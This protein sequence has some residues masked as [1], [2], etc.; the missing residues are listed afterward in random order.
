MSKRL[1]NLLEDRWYL[2]SHIYR[3]GWC[4]DPA[5]QMRLVIWNNVEMIRIN[6]AAFEFLDA[7]RVILSYK[8][9]GWIGLS[10]SQDE[11]RK[12]IDA[13]NSRRLSA[14]GFA[15]RFQLDW[16]QDS[17][18]LLFVRDKSLVGNMEEENAL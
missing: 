5:P 13:G 6:R 9:G 18:F 17:L 14:M 16:P 11:G 1:D 12:L 15:H 2:H 7:P 4:C 3:T 8:Q 10:P